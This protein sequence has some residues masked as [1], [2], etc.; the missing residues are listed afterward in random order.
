MIN[1]V[2]R[3]IERLEKMLITI[4]KF[5]ERAPEGSLKYQKKGREI[6]FYQQYKNE[7]SNKWENRYIK[8]EE[9][10]LAKDL[11]QKQYYTKLEPILKKGIRALRN[12]RKANYQEEAENT[13]SELSPIRKTLVSPLLLSKEELIHKWKTE[14]YE[15]NPF[16]PENLRYET[17]QG[18]LVR[19][20]SEVIIAN[21]LYNHKEDI[22]YKYERPLVLLKEGNEK[23]IY[24]DFTVVNRHNGRII[25]WEHAGRMDDSYYAN[26]FVKK[27]NTYVANGYLPG[28]DVLVTY[29]TMASPLDVSIVKR[30]VTEF[31]IFNG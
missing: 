18:E 17:E 16:Y 15:S 7:E 4:N 21:I 31:C 5:K 6:F 24:P 25:Y 27:M 12:F 22:L 19:S 30:M 2:N 20:K 1:E 8:R 28:K 23:T 10:A 3:E 14:E 13:Y 26:E 11:A 29:E 9:L